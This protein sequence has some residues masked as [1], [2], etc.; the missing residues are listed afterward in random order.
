[1]PRRSSGIAATSRR[2]T[3]SSARETIGRPAANGVIARRIQNAR[4]GRN[5]P[6]ST[7]GGMARS[8]NVSAAEPAR[9]AAAIAIAARKP[10][11]APST[12]AIGA[13]MMLPAKYAPRTMPSARPSSA[14]AALL[15]LGARLAND[16]WIGE[17]VDRGERERLRRDE[18]VLVRLLLDDGLAE[19]G[20][21]AGDRL[22]RDRDVWMDRGEHLH[23][24]AHVGRAHALVVA[25]L[26]HLDTER[27][28]VMRPPVRKRCGEHHVLV[29]GVLVDRHG[30]LRAGRLRGALRAGDEPAQH[31]LLVAT[32]ESADGETRA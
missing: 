24:V 31:L 3:G 22:L 18:R 25:R 6:R 23:H 14:G 21:V 20:R 5:R 8:P 7:C 17:H 4:G 28:H 30:E 16:V 13:P 11:D 2:S 29:A 1:M 26:E 10:I 9:S 19:R 27:A 15:E 32:V 12:P